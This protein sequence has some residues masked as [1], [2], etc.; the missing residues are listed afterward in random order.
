MCKCNT[1]LNLIKCNEGN[2]VGNMFKAL[3]I[4]PKN[5][6]LGMTVSCI[7]Y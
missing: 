5:G 6:L 4:S 3:E 7:N 2:S 1:L